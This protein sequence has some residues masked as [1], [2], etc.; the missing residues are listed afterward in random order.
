MRRN[1]TIG[2]GKGDPEEGNG[3]VIKCGGEE[4]GRQWWGR[5][6]WWKNGVEGGGAGGKGAEGGRW[7]RGDGGGAWRAV[8]RDGMGIAWL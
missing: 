1:Y 8:R 7:E 4:N 2:D 5:E 3:D 6:R